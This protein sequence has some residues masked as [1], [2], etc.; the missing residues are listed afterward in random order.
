[1]PRWIDALLAD[2]E[3]AIAGTLE[4]GRGDF[5]Q[6]LP[7]L[8]KVA[9]AIRKRSC[10]ALVLRPQNSL[11][12]EQSRCLVRALVPTGV[13]DRLM[14]DQILGRSNE[15]TLIRVLEYGIAAGLDVNIKDASDKPCFW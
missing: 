12:S 3:E 15:T 10:E 9:D 8:P 1:M 6:S 7:V 13:M 2:W 11:G 5:L 14:L 4:T